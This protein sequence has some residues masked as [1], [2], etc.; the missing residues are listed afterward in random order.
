VLSLSVG[1]TGSSQSG[2]ALVEQAG[3]PHRFSG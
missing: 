3:Q 1:D 2:N